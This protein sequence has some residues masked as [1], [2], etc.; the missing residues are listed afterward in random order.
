MN[1]KNAANSTDNSSNWIRQTMRQFSSQEYHDSYTQAVEAIFGENYSAGI[2]SLTELVYSG[3]IPVNELT[4]PESLIDRLQN[5]MLDDNSQFERI[6]RLYMEISEKSSRVLDNAYLMKQ[7]I[8]QT[9]SENQVIASYSMTILS[10]LV[11][12]KYMPVEEVLASVEYQIRDTSLVEPAFVLMEKILSNYLANPGV[13]DRIAIMVGTYMDVM[14]TD[15]IMNTIAVITA[16]ILV[17]D[18][19]YTN[20]FIDKSVISQIMDRFYELRNRVDEFT[21]SCL[22][23]AYIVMNNGFDSYLMEEID[24]TFV[25]NYIIRNVSNQAVIT[26][27]FCLLSVIPSKYYDLIL[28]PYLS[29]ENMYCIIDK[30]VSGSINTKL[31]GL[32]LLTSLLSIHDISLFKRVKEYGLID[33]IRKLFSPEIGADLQRSLLMLLRTIIC[34]YRLISAEE[35]KMVQERVSDEFMDDMELILE[36]TDDEKL[37]DEI[38]CTINLISN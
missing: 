20:Y 38:I 30:M 34:N 33:L 4:V 11:S 2:E 22:R 24:L 21:V 35:Y 9:Y 32:D 1:Y 28:M 26:K 16:K 8:S 3:N 14:E 7:F 12:S 27:S 29:D 18:S 5:I 6:F 23:L 37:S 36:T 19:R 25:W 10:N 31:S 15:V 17:Q 13:V